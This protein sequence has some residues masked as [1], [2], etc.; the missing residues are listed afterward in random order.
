MIEPPTIETQLRAAN[1]RI[2]LLE[3]RLKLIE[4]NRSPERLALEALAKL[5]IYLAWRPEFKLH[6]NLWDNK[7]LPLIREIEGHLH[8]P[9]SDR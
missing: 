6:P 1:E 7:V 8:L 9:R 4:A 2:D 3:K 5:L